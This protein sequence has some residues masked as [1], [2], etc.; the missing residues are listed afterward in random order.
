ML[1][2]NQY[3]KLKSIQMFK[4]T[5]AKDY[6][7]NKDLYKFFLLKRLIKKQEVREYQGFVI[8]PEGEKELYM[9]KLERYHFWIPTILSI[10]AII[11]SILAI[12]T[13]N[14][15]LWII[16]KELLQLQQ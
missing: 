15:E 16:L 2:P 7:E 10:I 11:T 12:F 6:E 4:G 13:Q 3:R 14:G 1:T 5:K 9:Y 8:T